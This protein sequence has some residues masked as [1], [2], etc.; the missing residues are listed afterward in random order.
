MTRDEAMPKWHYWENQLAAAHA[1]G[2]AEERERCEKACPMCEPGV[3][4]ELHRL[5]AVRDAAEAMVPVMCKAGQCVE[6]D[7]LRAALDAAKDLP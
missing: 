2:V 7:A 4:E 1:R 3:V 6:C 5:R